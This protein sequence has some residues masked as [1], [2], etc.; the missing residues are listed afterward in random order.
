VVHMAPSRRL[1]RRQVEDGY[2]DVTG[3]VGPYYPTFTVFNVLC[4]R[5]IVVF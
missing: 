1:R 3:C 5:D 4:H 2:V